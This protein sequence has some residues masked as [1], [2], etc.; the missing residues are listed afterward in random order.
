MVV[1]AAETLKGEDKGKTEAGG[2]KATEG[3]KGSEITRRKILRYQSA[4]R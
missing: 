2:G 1:V 4:R 3:E